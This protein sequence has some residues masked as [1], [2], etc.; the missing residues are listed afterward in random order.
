[1]KSLR[2][3]V[4]LLYASIAF[5]QSKPT[6]FKA[7]RM[8]ETFTEWTVAENVN[9]EMCVKPKRDVKDACK[10]LERI[11]AGENL[12]FSTTDGKQTRTFS[13]SGGTLRQIE[14]PELMMGTNFE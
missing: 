8:G 10:R 1:M 7:H 5:G 3:A 2:L 4:I 12:D 9:M 6:Y 13:F 14:I 11:Q